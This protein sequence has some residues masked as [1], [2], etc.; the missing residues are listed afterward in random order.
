M[1]YLIENCPKFFPIGP[2]PDRLVSSNDHSDTP[3][4]RCSRS[5]LFC[6]L[7]YGNGRDTTIFGRLDT[8]VNA[9][10]IVNS[11]PETAS[12][13]GNMPSGAKSSHGKYTT[14]LLVVYP[15]RYVSPAFGPR[16][17]SQKSA[18]GFGG[19]G[20]AWLFAAPQ[21][22]ANPIS[23]TSI[24][25]ILLRWVWYQKNDAEWLYVFWL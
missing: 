2:S 18:A 17:S 15:G 6:T 22:S 16:P 10:V 1:R 13:S 5:T 11:V 19:G 7:L 25:R 4:T 23:N 3:S 14:G 21:S 24:V 12:R 20:G 8:S 9:L